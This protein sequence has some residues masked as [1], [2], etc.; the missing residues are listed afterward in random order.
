MLFASFGARGALPAWLTA[1]PVG[2]Q[3]C[4]LLCPCDKPSRG[5]GPPPRTVVLYTTHPATLFPRSTLRGK[6]ER[7]LFSILV[8]TPLLFLLTAPGCLS[9][10]C[11]VPLWRASGAPAQF[12]GKRR[13]VRWSGK[14]PVTIGIF[15]TVPLSFSSEARPDSGSCPRHRSPVAE[16]IVAE[17]DEDPL[18]P[19]TRPTRYGGRSASPDRASG[20]A[21]SARYRSTT[22]C[23]RT[24]PSFR[25]YRRR[26]RTRGTAALPSRAHRLDI[27]QEAKPDQFVGNDDLT[28]R[29]TCS[30]SR[31]GDG[32]RI[33]R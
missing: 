31:P 9:A 21:R 19:S 12:D 16:Q 33:S 18:G 2:S 4:S 11:A 30:F 1:W 3:S 26:A 17:L 13:M 29:R 20:R 24:S 7:I 6:P 14:W 15:A 5:A 32:G 10:S 27:A 25:W 23:R 22:A 8:R 28:R